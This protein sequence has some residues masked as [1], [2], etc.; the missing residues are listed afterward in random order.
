MDRKRNSSRALEHVKKINKSHN[1][2]L[3]PLSNDAQYVP[4]VDMMSCLQNPLSLENKCQTNPCC[5]LNDYVGFY[6]HYVLY[7]DCLSITT[8]KCLMI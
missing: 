8:F 7:S 5:S 1:A 3:I 6:L 2:P 4:L